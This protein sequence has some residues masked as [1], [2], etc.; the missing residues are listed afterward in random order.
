MTPDN[1][2]PV[3]GYE[4]GFVKPD[5]SRDLAAYDQLPWPVKEALDEAPLAISA[6]AALHH[7]RL[8]GVASV[9]REIRESADEFYVAAERETGVGRPRKPLGGWKRQF[10]R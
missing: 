7:I 2:L 3:Q 10:R 1:H 5:P 6:V 4:A 8:F 9:L